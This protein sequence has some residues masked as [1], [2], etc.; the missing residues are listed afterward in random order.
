MATVSA[1]PYRVPQLGP[2]WPAGHTD[3]EGTNWDDDW[4]DN[5]DPFDRVMGDADVAVEELGGMVMLNASGRQ[6]S[7]IGIY[8][9]AEEDEEVEDEEMEENGEDRASDGQP[10]IRRSHST[11]PPWPPAPSSP[12]WPPHPSSPHSR[13]LSPPWPPIPADPR[14]ADGQAPAPADTPIAGLPP[15]SIPPYVLSP[16]S[17]LPT[18]VSS[19][20]TGRAAA[21]A[22]Q[23][24][25]RISAL[26]QLAAPAPATLGTPITL[27]SPSALED[28]VQ[29]DLPSAPRHAN[30]RRVGEGTDDEDMDETKAAEKEGGGQPPGD[31]QGQP[32]LEKDPLRWLAS[33]GID[34]PPPVNWETVP[35]R[36]MQFGRERLTLDSNAQRILYKKNEWFDDQIIS[37]FGKLFEEGQ[38]YEWFENSS[39]AGLPAVRIFDPHMLADLPY[40]QDDRGKRFWFDKYFSYVLPKEGNSKESHWVLGKVEFE[41]KTMSF[42]NSLRGVGDHKQYAEWVRDSI[43]KAR[44][45]VGLR[46]PGWAGW[47]YRSEQVIQQDNGYDCGGWLLMN[48]LS[49]CRGFTRS[50]GPR[51]WAFRRALYS[52]VMGWPIA[53]DGK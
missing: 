35:W 32:T 18:P 1:S 23:E 45:V 19:R 52:Y 24:L 12:P 36:H 8:A 46:D 50:E 21:R 20:S 17:R 28:R 37:V 48:E 2:V 3:N 39:A 29:W 51:A 47:Q 53:S 34:V 33:S 27:P 44:E 7:G 4:S 42:L 5:S 22:A 43:T 13:S 31:N 9:G 40:I 30:A 10:A 14:P 6:R 25:E 15:S 49:I 26:L 11:S 41:T 38:P 16:P